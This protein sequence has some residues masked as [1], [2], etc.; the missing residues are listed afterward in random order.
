M[1]GTYNFIRKT[2]P[3]AFAIA[4]FLL[5]AGAKADIMLQLESV[6]GAPGSTGTFDV[7]LKNTG[8][9]PQNITGFNFEL[10]TAD[11]N[12][13]FTDV[14]TATATAAYIFSAS[15]FG[16]DITTMASGQTV[17]AG[18][19]DATFNG[20]D[21]AS[22]A[23][24]GLGWVSYSIAGGATNGEVA[25]IEFSAYPGTSLA[26]NNSINVDFIDGSGTITVLAPVPEPA[27]VLLLGAALVM[28]AGL[29]RRRRRLEHISTSRAKRGGCLAEKSEGI[30]MLGGIK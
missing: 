27:A 20:T 19:L 17:E 15:F 8:P 1:K 5:P 29:P 3:A 4:A 25:Q 22:G 7:L 11:P 18:D 23:T 9:S 24:Y 14:T 21:V 10:T 6:T 12:I 16:P 30:S 26:D 28:T 13:A 2:A